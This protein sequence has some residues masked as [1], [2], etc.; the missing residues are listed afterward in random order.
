MKL[1]F[2]EYV[3]PKALLREN[4][5]NEVQLQYSP[6]GDTAKVPYVGYFFNA[7][8]NDTVFILPKVFIS[9]N[10]KAFGRYEPEKIINLSYTDNPLKTNGDDEVVF[11]LSAWLYQAIDHFVERNASSSISQG[12]DIQNV[13]PIGEKCSKTII[14][15]IL[16]LRDF[17]KK[18][19]NLFTYISLI[20]ASGNNKVHWAK[21]ISKEQPLIKEHKP[22][23]IQFRN[24]SKV[25]NFNEELI[26]LFYS[27]LNYLRETYHFKFQLVQGYTLLKPSKIASMIEGGKGTRLLKKIRHNY[28]SDEL[29]ELWHLLYTFFEREENIC[30][31]KPY[32]E[33]LLVSKFNLV[34]EDM[35]DQLISDSI[36]PKELKEQQDGKIVDHIYLDKSVVD[37]NKQIYYIGDSKYYKETTNLGTNS[38]YKQ[39]TYAKNVIQVNINLFNDNKLPFNIRYRDELTEGYSITPNF[40]IRGTIDFTSISS[41]EL[42]LQK[43]Y[44][45]E[46]PNIHFKNRLFDRDTL[47]LQS[48]NVNFL[49]VMSAYV[50]RNDNETIKRKIRTMFRENFVEFID[51]KYDFWMLTPRSNSLEDAV[52]RNFYELNGKIYRPSDEA[53]YVILAL[54]RNADNKSLLTQINRDFDKQKYNLRSESIKTYA[55]IDDNIEFAA[56]NEVEYK[57]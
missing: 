48:Y 50:S 49:Y 53:T 56:E 33:R 51:S 39:F 25:L 30:S 52:K 22:Y 9:E 15:I 19:R 57:Q 44:N 54:D 4:L 2:E 37:T 7:Q 41:A 38:I 13:R 1:Y 8:I 28:F 18:H 34:F 11:E 5:S 27:V 16:S 17:Q 29:V 6:N 14:E 26:S 55:S 3:Y 23:Y 43:D 42:N 46:K 12:V 20:N 40:F 47:F 45:D 21:T 36:V 32:Q 24:K 10:R 31:G 35:I